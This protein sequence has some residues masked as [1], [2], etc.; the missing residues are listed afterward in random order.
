MP[1]CLCSLIIVFCLCF[2]RNR[3]RLRRIT[4]K[5]SKRTWRCDTARKFRPLVDFSSDHHDILKK[6]LEMSQ[7]D[8]TVVWGSY[9][10]GM[11]RELATLCRNIVHVC[12][13]SRTVCSWLIV[14]CDTD[15][16]TGKMWCAQGKF[17]VSQIDSQCLLLLLST[18]N[19]KA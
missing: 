19:I 2:G 5:E 8:P 6:S 15:A 16:C 7:L 18:K 10:L 11:W 12:S 3:Q 9:F 17:S 1:W 14:A 4:C 13:C